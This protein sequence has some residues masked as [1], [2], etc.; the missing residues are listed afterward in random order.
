MSTQTDSSSFSFFSSLA[1]FQELC[2]LLLQAD[3]LDLQ[4]PKATA[5]SRGIRASVS[6]TCFL[7]N[8]SRMDHLL[9]VRKTEHLRFPFPFE[10]EVEHFF[11]QL[12]LLSAKVIDYDCRWKT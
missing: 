7:L 11:L 4:R 6:V 10:I 2:L 9:R 5:R 12:P 8:Q 3:R 1:P